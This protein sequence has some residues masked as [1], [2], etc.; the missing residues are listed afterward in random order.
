MSLSDIDT[1]TH[2]WYHH[3][4]GNMDDY[5]TATSEKFGTGKKNTEN[6]IAKWDKGEVSNG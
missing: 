4:R 2:Y 3:A 5:E 6:M 1:N